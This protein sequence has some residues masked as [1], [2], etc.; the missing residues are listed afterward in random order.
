MQHYHLKF[1]LFFLAISCYFNTSIV[2]AVDN[3]VESKQI[4]SK[5]SLGEFL[6]QSNYLSGKE[7]LTCSSC[8]LL[9]DGGDDNISFSTGDNKEK[10]TTNTPTIFHSANNF[11]MGWLGQKPSIDSLV[12]AVITSPQAN[13]G[14]AA[15]IMAKLENDQIIN[16]QFN[17]LYKNGITME[18]IVDALIEYIKSLSIPNSLYDEYLSGNYQA[19]NLKQ[20][21]GF[22]LFKSYG[23][24][25]CHQGANLGG[26]MYQKL[27]VF[28]NYFE[29]EQLKKVDF[30]RYNITKVERDKFYFRVP[31]LRNVAVT[32]PYFHDGSIEKLDE[33]IALMG[34]YQ[35][36]RNIP[37]ED[38]DKII[39]FLYTLTNKELS[40][41]E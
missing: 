11:I 41:I 37:E 1:Y 35:L 22:N 20:V 21:E 18:N 19:F 29:N 26:N 38:R 17:L 31:S 14:N 30:G 25:T 24:D 3:S 32:A 34:K 39:A 15:S 5:A 7:Q 33:V 4:I 8:H 2:I 28:K 12:R 40:N 27:G 36:G 13:G 23:C 10:R 6:F 16:E 9:N